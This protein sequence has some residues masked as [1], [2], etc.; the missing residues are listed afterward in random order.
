MYEGEKPWRVP[1]EEAE[2]LDEGEDF[3][4]LFANDGPTLNFGSLSFEDVGPVRAHEQLEG[5]DER[6]SKPR[7]IV[8]SQGLSAGDA[9]ALAEAIAARGEGVTRCILSGA[10]LFGDF[11]L[12]AA[13]LVGPVRARIATLSYNV[14]NVDALW[15]AMRNGAIRELDLITSCFFYS[16]YRATL[17]RMLVTNLPRERTRYAV[18]NTHAKVALLLPEHGPAWCI[19]GSANLRSCD[20]VEQIIVSVGDDEATRFHGKWMDRIL[21]RFE[22]RDRAKLQAETWN[23][24]TGA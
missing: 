22:L 14:E 6:L 12:R 5:L 1:A 16:H 7:P 8:A 10:F 19:E 20:A 15:T 21:E 11:L 17:W 24:I 18:C 4:A 13:Q 9:A 3:S 2:E 23:A